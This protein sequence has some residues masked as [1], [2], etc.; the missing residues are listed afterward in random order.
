MIIRERVSRSHAVLNTKSLVKNLAD[1]SRAIGLARNVRDNPVALRV[2][3]ALTS[4]DHAGGAVTARSSEDHR[5]VLGA[6][7]ERVEC[8]G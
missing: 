3:V 2:I 1:G 8:C 5:Q 4:A 7:L 6:A